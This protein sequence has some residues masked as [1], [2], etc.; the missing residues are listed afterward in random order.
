MNKI[1][2]G[3]RNFNDKFKKIV[4]SPESLNFYF[5]TYILS[6][7]NSVEPDFYIVSYPKSGRTW[8]RFMLQK[9][10][11]QLGITPQQFHDKSMLRISS[12]KVIKFE[13]D[14]SN[15]VPIPRSV[16]EL[17]FNVSL[18]SGKKIIF[19]VRDPR[20]VLVSSWYHLR[21]RERIYMEDLSSFMHDNLVGINKII[22]FMNMW[23][24]NSWVPAAF[25][26]ITYEDIH[27]DPHTT[28]SSIIKF[29]GMQVNSEA[30]KRAVTESAFEKM[31]HMEKRGELKDPWI[32]PGS[33]TSGNSMKIRKGMVGGYRSELSEKDILYLDSVIKEKLNPRLP[34][35]RR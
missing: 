3:L 35:H 24:D 8:V 28:F 31:N 10:I 30:L 17:S 20:D 4:R 27:R 33:K 11:E 7:L 5:K 21:F 26:P 15:W 9:Y 29:L 23:M 18:Y 14:Q 32:E 34:Y 25:Y 1:I 6:K 12:D 13:H 19:L 16:S 22:A 2:F